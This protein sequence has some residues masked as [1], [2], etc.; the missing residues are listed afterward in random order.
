MFL[1]LVLT[2]GRGTI[3]YERQ[4]VN[5]NYVFMCTD[6]GSSLQAGMRSWHGVR[7]TKRVMKKPCMWRLHSTV[8]IMTCFM[9]YVFML[10]YL[11]IWAGIVSDTGD[12]N[13]MGWSRAFGLDEL[14]FSCFNCFLS[15]LSP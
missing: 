9:I 6:W 1:F 3:L 7:E 2:D 11:A 15:V 8:L 13:G 4:G 5:L 10:L 12:G 14:A